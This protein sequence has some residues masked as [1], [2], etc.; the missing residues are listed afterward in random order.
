MKTE[1][2]LTWRWAGKPIPVGV[3]RQGAGPILLLLPALSSISTRG[4]MRPLQQ[5]LA[6]AFTTVSVDWP[7]FGDSAKPRVDWRPGTYAAFLE[8]LL[9]QVVPKPFATVAAGHGAS[10]A[11]KQAATVP[12]STGRLCLVAPTWRGPLPT[13]IGKHHPAFAW[14]A[15][16]IDQ[17]LLGQF[18]YSLNVNRLMV[19]MMGRRH[20]YADPGWLNGSRLDEKL[21]VTRAKGARH[22]SV[23][24]VAGE[25]DI[26]RSRAEFV[27][28][29]ERIANPILVLYGAGTPPKSKAEME[30][31][32]ALPNVRVVILPLGKLSVHEE[33]PDP[34]ADAIMSFLVE[35]PSPMTTQR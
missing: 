7:G 23:R 9:T 8:H 16:A 10:Y 17:P 2:D 29:A 24:F 19:G 11:L 1:R 21:A 13:M 4:E 30:A 14:I 35:G 6:A 28:L 20:V 3:E 18:L 31:L 12:G 32:A 33:F 26:V 34:V 22:A 25:L 5:R 15:R 27:A